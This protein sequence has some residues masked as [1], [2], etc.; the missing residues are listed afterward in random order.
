MSSKSTSKNRAKFWLFVNIIIVAFAATLVFPNYFNNS[1]DWVN[2]KVGISL[3]HFWE[4]PFR[5]GLDLQGGTHLV[6]EADVS[7]IP[8]TEQGDAIQ[9]VRDVIE[10]R[11]NSIGVSE[12]LVQ[13]TKVGE[14]YRVI[15]ELAGISDVNQAIKLIGETPLLEFRKENDQPARDLTDAE[16][17]EMTSYNKE[18][19]A[20]ADEAL[21]KVLN[22]GSKFGDLVK[23]L[24]QDAAHIKDNGGLFG[25]IDKDSSEAEIKAA[26]Q[27]LSAGQFVRKTVDAENGY[28]VVRVDEVNNVKE[29][30]ASHILICFKGATSCPEDKQISKEDALAKI[31]DLKAQATAKNFAQLAKDN[32]TEPVAKTSGGSLGYFSEGQ[33]VKEFEDVAFVQRI[34][35]ISDPVE[36]QFGY[37]ILYKS[38]ERTSKAYKISRIFL[39][40]KVKAD[41]VQ[42]EQ[43]INTGLNGTHLKRA[44]VQFQGQT[45]EPVVSLEFNDAGRDLFAALTKENLNKVIAIYLDGQAIS[46]PRV[47]SEILT[48]QAVITGRF[49]IDE[50]KQLARRLNAGALPVPIELITQQTV[51]PTLG[52]ASLDA[53]VKAGLIGFLLIAIFMIVLYRIPG[54]FSII[55]LGFYAAFVMALFKLLGV[56]MTLSGIAGM[57]LSI[58]IAVDANVLIFERLKEEVGRGK[59]YQSAIDEAFKRAWPSIRDGNAS[60]LITAFILTQFTTSFIRGFAIT[61]AV[62]VLLSMYTAIT[63]TRM[64]LKV[65]L[66]NKMVE[67]MPWLFLAK[68]S[69]KPE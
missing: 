30:E 53:S 16:R 20:K 5:L 3:P 50:S 66:S 57:I 10:R 36:T 33:M 14:T 4:K 25:T 18:Q 7:K 52:Q 55:S 9:G 43:F 45:Q 38:N 37:H 23:D 69:N 67:K 47:Q 28:S 62:G 12:P 31:K 2:E 26:V 54:V 21:L 44:S 27:G 64:W 8:G 19:K 22:D 59:P 42:P 46:L 32:S 24:S 13:T 1:V 6:Y 11:V 17:A 65:A 63:V 56:T 61:L 40:K 51:G 35:S 68:K 48:G 29:V 39:K 49:T 34:G 41:F 58:G 15:V 60:T